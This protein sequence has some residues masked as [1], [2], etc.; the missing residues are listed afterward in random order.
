MAAKETGKQRAA[1]IPLDYFK[2]PTR[3]ERWK[4]WLGVIALVVSAGWLAAGLLR[5]DRGDLRYSRGPVA[6][7]HQTWDANCAACHEAFVPIQSDHWA[8]HWMPS[9]FSSANKEHQ[10]TTCHAGPP[11]HASEKTPPSCAAC[12]RE[13]RGRDASLV[14]LSDHDCTQCHANIAAA[15]KPGAKTLLA[16]PMHHIRGFSKAEGHGDFQHLKATAAKQKLKFNHK[17]H[18]A[19]GLVTP[20]N[21]APGLTLAK[22]SPSD[23]QRYKDKTGTMIQLECA[24]CHQL[25]RGDRA[26]GDYMLPI[27]YEAHCQACHP[28]TIERTKDEDRHSSAIAVPHRLQPQEIRRY[29]EGVYTAKVLK[30]DLKAFEQFIGKRPLPGKSPEIKPVRDYYKKIEAAEKN[31]YFGKKTCGECHDVEPQGALTAAPS[32]PAMPPSFRIA[33]THVPQVW[34]AHAKFNHVAHRGVDCRACHESG[35]KDDGQTKITLT[36]S[37]A[38]GDT[39]IPGMDNCVQCH[40]PATRTGGGARHDCTQCHRYH[41]GDSPLEGIGAKARDPGARRAIDAFLAGP[42]GQPDGSARK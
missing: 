29:L 31:L 38:S 3:L 16:A 40:A 34:F 13:H 10:C 19:P 4:E 35:F 8:A 17:L 36:E 37:R 41:H 39:F 7:V 20:E 42:K 11:H 12:H 25:D 2:H 24:S 9:W 6:N 21:G 22:L 26:A 14:R 32:D 18:M 5:Q 27:R 15:L 23:Q 28:L 30:N 1:R 33:A